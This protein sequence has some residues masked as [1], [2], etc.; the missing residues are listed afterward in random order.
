M[1]APRETTFAVKVPPSR[2]DGVGNGIRAGAFRRSAVRTAPVACVRAPTDLLH[3]CGHKTPMEYWQRVRE[4]VASHEPLILGMA[5]VIVLD[6]AGRVL[7]HRRRVEDVWDVPSGY[8]NY[9]ESVPETGRREVEEET[10]WAVGD[11]FLVGEISGPAVRHTYGNGD[12]VEPLIMI[13]AARATVEIGA[14]DL[15][16]TREVRAFSLTNLPEDLDQTARKVLDLF[17]ERRSA[18]GQV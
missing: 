3:D 2:A 11:M 18:I 12:V 9:G 6:D 7:L 15:A 5:H 8:V 1:A 13:Y 16:E 10:G 4:A 14:F 17:V